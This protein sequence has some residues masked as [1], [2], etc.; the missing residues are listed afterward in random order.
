MNCDDE[1]LSD[2]DKALSFVPKDFRQFVLLMAE[3][4]VGEG[5]KGPI[6]LFMAL[7]QD[8]R[9]QSLLE[10]AI[11]IDSDDLDQLLFSAEDYYSD[12]VACSTANG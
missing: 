7:R 3:A 5:S 4:P 10:L 12:A 6:E 11:S 2:L 1:T 8:A 9:L